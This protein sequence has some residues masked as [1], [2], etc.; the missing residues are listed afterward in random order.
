MLVR[1]GPTSTSGS[2]PG[3]A[4]FRE[5]PSPSRVLVERRRQAS[6]PEIRCD[7][8]AAK[9][10][11]DDQERVQPIPTTWFPATRRAPTRPR[12]GMCCRFAR[13][14]P[15]APSIHRHEKA[16]CANTGLSRN[17]IG[18]VYSGYRSDRRQTLRS[19]SGQTTRRDFVPAK[20]GSDVPTRLVQHCRQAHGVLSSGVVPLRHHTA[21]NRAVTDNAEARSLTGPRHADKNAGTG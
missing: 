19:Y 21:G 6:A 20:G 5:D 10:K 4:S 1:H 15:A 7:E 17:Q 8:N 12:A 13:D 3:R 11:G 9:R 18:L 2:P 14:H 16:R